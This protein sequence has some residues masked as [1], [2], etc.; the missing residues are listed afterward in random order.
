[1]LLRYFLNDF[2]ML[3]VVLIITGITCVFKFHM[4]CVYIVR[5]LYF[6]KFSASFI[7]IIIIIIITTIFLIH[8]SYNSKRF[9]SQHYL[10]P[11]LFSLSCPPSMNITVPLESDSGP[12]R[13]LRTWRRPIALPGA[14]WQLVSLLASHYSLSYLT[15]T[16]AVLSS[17]WT[18]CVILFCFHHLLYH[19]Y[20]CIGVTV[21]LSLWLHVF[22]FLLATRLWMQH[23]AT[24]RLSWAEEN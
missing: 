16:A 2:D 5:S 10:K 23:F 9:I 22:C 3:P 1:M 24:Q 20:P 19:C 7:T 11:L 12:Q 15:S 6:R 21:Q 13:L 4:H 14:I 8:T 18:C 17:G